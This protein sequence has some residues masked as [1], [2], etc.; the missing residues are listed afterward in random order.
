MDDSAAVTVLHMMALQEEDLFRLP[1]VTSEEYGIF[2]ERDDFNALEVWLGDVD[3]RC[4]ELDE[5]V[6]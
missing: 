3:Q 1:G 4:E 6:D 5:L 2:L